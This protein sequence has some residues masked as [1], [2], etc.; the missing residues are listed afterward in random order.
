MD[1]MNNV[2]IT[3]SATSDTV[4]TEPVYIPVILPPQE[5]PYAKI[6]RAGFIVGLALVSM[7]IAQLF[8]SVVTVIAAALFGTVDPVT[9]VKAIPD[10]SDLHFFLYIIQYIVMFTPPLLV[11]GLAGKTKG[12]FSLYGKALKKPESI[13]GTKETEKY[14]KELDE[15]RRLKSGMLSEVFLLFFAAVGGTYAMRLVANYVEVAFNMFGFVSPEIFSNDPEGILGWIFYFIVIC[16]LAPVS[17]EMF[18]RG[19]VLKMLTPYGNG[20]AIACQAI[21]FAIFHGTLQQIPYTLVGGLIMG[22]LAA[23]HGGIL[24]SLLLHFLNNLFSMLLSLCIP[25]SVQENYTVSVLINLTVYVVM[26]VGGIIA[27][28]LLTK[29]DKAYFKT[30]SETDETPVADKL[31]GFSAFNAFL[32]HPVLLV[33]IISTIGM[34]LLNMLLTGLKL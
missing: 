7:F 31:Y 8:L 29:K 32:T 16:I 9:G 5:N 19:G 4:R 14:E 21:L 23:R 34:M 17:E 2:N 15:H 30:S 27:V 24:P 25:K 3:Q 33:Y 28:K 1:E 26:I 20:F 13:Y 11:I 6:R 10:T 12:M 18:F 22:Y